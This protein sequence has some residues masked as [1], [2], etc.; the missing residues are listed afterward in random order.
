MQ[1]S[2]ERGQGLSRLCRSVVALTLLAGS[3]L[4]AQT[5]PTWEELEAR[6]AR[7][8]S[9]DLRIGDV[10][11]PSLPKENH[12]LGR[13]ANFLH[14]DT[15]EQVIRREILFHPGEAV[16]A[17]LIHETERNLRTFRF[18][19]NAWIE[20]QVDETGAVHAVVHTTDAWT[21]KGSAGFTQVGGQRSFGFSL[22]EA[23]LLGFGKDL[24]LAHEKTPERSIDTVQYLDRQ[25]LG[26]QWTLDSR[27][28]ALSDG[29][30]RFVEL[31]RPYRGLETPWSMTFRASASDATESVYNLE[32]TAYTFSSGRESALVE[33]SMATLVAEGR[34][35]RLGGGLDLKRARYGPLL[36]LDAGN[37]PAPWL[38]DRLLRGVHATWS[39]FDDQFHAFVDLAGMTHPEDYNLGWEAKVSVGSYL[40]S[41]G[42]DV[43]SPFFRAS[44]SKGWT[45]GA[46]SLLLL[47][48]SGAARHEA[49]GW[50]D[51]ALNLSFIAYHQGFRSQ[52]QAAYVQLDA[53]HRPEPESY[54]YLGGMDGMRGYGNHLLLGDRRWMTS[55]E[56]RIN[57]SYNWLGILQLG[58]VVYADGGA[59]RRIDTG[60]WSRTYV[61][62]G[63]GLR[64][65]NLKSSIGRVFLLTI[66]FPLVREPGTEH[67]QFIVGDI[68]KF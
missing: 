40:R 14:I 24:I 34:A 36:T 19:K 18:L 15:R 43:A 51:A 32:R 22:H 5:A 60:R 42:S 55:L 29:K 47:R 67:H 54:L 61:D 9:I 38:R 45:P 50:Q 26:T 53:V 10:F 21:L 49:D 11:D 66:A 25:I 4:A 30:T 62:V 17:R 64:L 56:E 20:P 16:N 39:L 35:L 52:T 58:F 68:V 41:L 28:Q 63:G 7:I 3:M 48:T 65:G 27:Y 2:P 6:Q 31:T 37:L 23:N 57:T 12:W 1:I 59:I 8:A 33:G 44:A 46:S 13:A